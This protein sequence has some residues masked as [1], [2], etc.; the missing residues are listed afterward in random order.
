MI[1]EKEPN[2]VTG[3]PAF[4]SIKRQCDRYTWK[5]DVEKIWILKN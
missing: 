1:G 4:S 5:E 2:L 3:L